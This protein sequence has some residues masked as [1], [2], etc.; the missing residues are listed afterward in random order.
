MQCFMPPL[1]KRENLITM[2]YTICG[3]FIGSSVKDIQYVIT[4][5]SEENNCISDHQNGCDKLK[6]RQ[7]LAC[8]PE[9]PCN[10]NRHRR[11]HVCILLSH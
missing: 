8:L 1:P 11:M 3:S 9:N 10:Q 6:E 4:E 5:R 7:S 2:S